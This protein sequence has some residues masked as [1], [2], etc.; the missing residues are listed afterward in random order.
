MTDPIRN[1]YGEVV[2][3]QLTPPAQPTAR[4]GAPSTAGAMLTTAQ[5]VAEHTMRTM[6]DQ[7]GLGGSMLAA[8][9]LGARGGA[10]VVEFVTEKDIAGTKVVVYRQTIDGLEVF[11]ASLGMQMDAQS[12]TPQ[13][14]QSSIHGTGTIENPGAKKAAATTREVC[15]TISAPP[16]SAM[17]RSAATVGTC[18]YL[19]AIVVC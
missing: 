16:P 11:E 10:P 14:A 15:M 2:F 13:T 19:S 1:E 17:P 4:G 7:L 12:L 8:D 5:Q 3:A 18:A 9:A 6:R